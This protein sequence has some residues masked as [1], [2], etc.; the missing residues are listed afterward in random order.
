MQPI[1]LL[2]QKKIIELHKPIFLD[3]A[4]CGGG[5]LALKQWSNQD[6]GYGVCEACFKEHVE[7]YGIEVAEDYFGKAGIN[8]TL[9]RGAHEA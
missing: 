1:K 9:E 7:K 6:E 8:H 4:C 3:C 5:A 2:G